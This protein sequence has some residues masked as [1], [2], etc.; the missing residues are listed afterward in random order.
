[1]E[2]DFGFD[3]TSNGNLGA[4]PLLLGSDPYAG[5]R[6]SPESPVIDA[7][8]GVSAPPFDRLMAP[9]FDDPV[10][11]NTGIPTSDG[12]FA[13]MGAYE[14]VARL[15]DAPDLVAANLS[16][17]RAD[18][19]PGD[20]ATVTWTTANESTF[21]AEAPWRDTIL[22]SPVPALSARSQV[23]TTLTTSHTGALAS[24]ETVTESATFT[25]PGLVGNWYVGVKVNESQAV[26]EGANIANN[27][28]FASTPITI[29]PP[30]VKT[31]N[32]PGRAGFGE[33]EPVL[34]GLHTDEPSSLELSINWGDPGRVSVFIARGRQPSELEWDVRETV[35]S[36]SGLEMSLSRV[37]SQNTW[38][39]VVPESPNLADRSVEVE[40]REVS[41]EISR[42]SPETLPIARETELLIEGSGFSPETTFR[43][44]GPESIEP[45]TIVIDADDRAILTL[46]TLAREAGVYHIEASDEGQ[47]ASLPD[48]VTLVQ[49]SNS[50]LS[51]AFEYTVSGP[52]ILRA[53]RSTPVT[54]K[55]TNTSDRPENAPLIK[56]A[57][58]KPGI[59][60]PSAFNALFN[61]RVLELTEKF[62]PKM[63][64]FFGAG[65]EA[66]SMA[67]LNAMMEAAKPIPPK[68]LQ[69]TTLL[70]INEE[71]PAAL[72]PPGET[73][74]F[75]VQLE[76]SV[77]QADDGGGAGFEYFVF[78]FR[79][80]SWNAEDVLADLRPDTVS[81]EA[82]GRMLANF[83]GILDASVEEN[84]DVDNHGEAFYQ[85]LLATANHFSKQDAYI[86]DP[87]QLLQF[88]LMRAA[89]FGEIF[90]RDRI[91]PF[92]R[93]S[94][95]LLPSLL[96]A[97]GAGEDP[98]IS[99]RLTGGG[100]RL[101]RYAS[102]QEAWYPEAFGDTGVMH[103]SATGFILRES[104][105]TVLNFNGTG[106]LTSEDHPL[107]GRTAYTWSGSNLVSIEDPSGDVINLS[108]LASGLVN[109][110]SLPDGRVLNFTYNST[111]DTL[112]SFTDPY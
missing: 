111:L 9:R 61:G 81:D 4:D 7:A 11:A 17:P 104:D 53:G 21:V 49:Y 102:R 109:R 71:F 57:S 30:V 76:P 41:L 89:A 78:E 26:V 65:A 95:D 15:T 46:N 14:F 68:L 39:L 80:G 100:E 62:I 85:R 90:R 60:N 69:A 28:A 5:L 74:V 66:E 24:G 48:A 1:I 91:G 44:E 92:G 32:S 58:V 18:F 19:V 99:V 88:T 87:N 59:R 20:T 42:G 94:D 106:L 112:S 103:E 8:N 97:D 2:G 47:T 54:V 52:E 101:F 22:L 36:V 10:V 86:S 6:P 67:R 33:L 77:D 35:D 98:T 50:I 45:E 70:A 107:R 105:G 34:F 96:F 56:I 27:V 93:G 75:E 23:V 31:D 84:T 55:V 13:D 25:V 82:W 63:E 40:V 79:G 16:L 37:Y 12:A 3:L 73:L 29:T 110:I 64:Q 72:V 108:H 38:L 51:S 43:L 83:V